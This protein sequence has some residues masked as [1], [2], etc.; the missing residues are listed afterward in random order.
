MDHQPTLWDNVA[1]EN[2][3]RCLSTLKLNEG[4]G[5]FRQAL[6]SPMAQEESIQAAITTCE[7]WRSRIKLPPK[8]LTLFSHTQNRHHYISEFLEDYT[9]YHFSP[10]MKELRK[11]LM[12]Y[13][14]NLIEHEP[15]PQMNYMETTLDLLMDLEEYQ[16][17]ESLAS[18]YVKQLQNGAENHALFYFLA[19]A[20]CLNGNKSAGCSTYARALLYYPDKTF[21]NRIEHIKSEKLIHSQGM[22]MA[23][24]YGRL[25]GILPYIPINDE[26]QPLSD[27]HQHAIQSYLLLQKVLKSMNND[28]NIHHRRQLKE[29]APALYQAYLRRLEQQE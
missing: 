2:G 7:Y 26:I 5:Q 3:Y 28:D 14:A 18:H 22:E 10:R 19:Q 24:A 6:Q 29:L 11:G 25:Y 15:E 20:Q 4:I 13:V 27:K 17:M 21:V 9:Q 16:K 8:Q 1:L 12:G 23:P